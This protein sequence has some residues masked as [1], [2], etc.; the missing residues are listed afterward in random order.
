MALTLS[1]LALLSV[2]WFNGPGLDRSPAIH[3]YLSLVMVGIGVVMA[4][5]QDWFPL[6]LW[7]FCCANALRFPW[8]MTQIVKLSTAGVLY[9]LVVTI[10]QYMTAELLPF[11]LL[12]IVSVALAQGTL[13]FLHRRWSGNQNHT[14][15]LLVMGFASALALGV[16]Q[17]WSWWLFSGIFLIPFALRPG[18]AYLWSLTGVVGLAVIYLPFAALGALVGAVAYLPKVA[19]DWRTSETHPDHGRCRI[20]FMFLGLWWQNGW[21][22]RCFGLGPDSWRSIVDQV[23]QA[24]QANTQRKLTGGFFTHPHNEYVHI[25]FEQGLVGLA[26]VLGLIGSLLWHAWTVQ[27]ALLIPALTLCAIAFTC[28]PWTTPYEVGVVRNNRQEYDPFGCIGMVAVTALLVALL[29]A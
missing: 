16:M 19:Y 26:L 8:P 1:I 7:T 23:S 25:V 27:P 12:C 18:Q 13:Y 10:R 22:A 21:K 9:L 4:L 3:R 20:W 5:Q 28:F 29:T 11:A 24:F 17:H 15:M 2:T 6:A 14:D